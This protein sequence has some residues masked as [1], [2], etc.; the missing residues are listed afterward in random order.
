MKAIA[1]YALIT[2]VGGF[3]LAGC[4]GGSDGIIAAGTDAQANALLP[5]EIQARQA[6]FG[7]DNV[8]AVTGNLP[9]DKVIFSWLSNSSYAVSLAGRLMLMDTGVSRLE[10]TPGR[11]P[12]VVQDI[13]NLR[14]E[15]I[16]IGSGEPSTADNAAYIAGRTGAVVFATP[17]TCDALNSDF[18]RLL[19][20]ASIQG[21][22]KT[23]FAASTL[24]C[25]GLTTRGSA[26][27]VER[28]RV[29]AF[30][31][32]A[33]INVVRHLHGVT[34]ARDTDLAVNAVPISGDPRDPTLFP[35]GTSLKPTGAAQ[36]GQMDISTT[37]NPATPGASLLY[38]ITMRGGTNFSFAWHDTTGALKEGKGAG[39]AGTTSDGLRVRQLLTALPA[40][41][42]NLGAL[43]S[44]NI[45]NNGMR[46]L[47]MYQQ[48]L[49][50][51][52]FIPNHHT[53][54]TGSPESSSLSLFASYL[55]QL[56]I[57]N[58]DRG[59]WADIRWPTD[60]SHYAKPLR[61]EVNN[62]TWQRPEK[63]ANLQST[64]ELLPS[65]S[66]DAVTIRQ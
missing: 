34:V 7:F 33:C 4:F 18:A 31:S 58:I 45:A 25:T 21:N 42:L 10:V 51:L 26:P 66:S 15:A 57:M 3:G 30:D 50:P 55:R 53:S 9:Q 48:A 63:S 40:A 56:D 62:P 1:K 27:G 59:D 14:P 23:R 44:E 8:D 36:A 6:V 49:K 60:P 28:V 52:I 64:C 13:T 65:G 12:F 47:V 37:G 32:L 19:G 24:K 11:T 43:P 35:S 16:L 22:A 61:F 39:Y 41:D 2:T 20:N 17:E 29:A 46:D 54:G 5:E 38:H